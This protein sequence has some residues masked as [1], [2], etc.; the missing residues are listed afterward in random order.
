MDEVAR[1]Y[2]NI[3]ALGRE[4]RNS[5]VIL[6]IRGANNFI[7]AKITEE[8]V[9]AG[10]TVM[11]LGCGKGG[12]LRKME[13]R[14]IRRYHGYDIADQSI[15][16]AKR[17]ARGLSFEAVLEAKDVYRERIDVVPVDKV[18]SQ[19]SFHYAFSS[20]ESLRIALGNVRRNLREGGL[21]VVTVPNEQTVKRRRSKHGNKFG[22]KHYRIEFPEE[23]NE[24]GG[25]PIE[26]GTGE[27]REM[28]EED[29]ASDSVLR[30]GKYLFYLQ[31]ALSGCPE[32]LVPEEIFLKEAGRAGLAL[33]RSEE[34]LSLLNRYMK[35]DRALYNKMVRGRLNMEEVAVIELY[36]LMVFERQLGE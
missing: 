10:D 2:N 4:E 33:L 34:F 22:N 18:V 36:K 16:E 29:R 6:R 25:L 27:I 24:E 30:K 9:A 11:D 8:Y 21:F 17:R 15:E 3:K 31:E 19:F 13:R 12:D 5:S 32:Y 1:H 7:K 23:E 14:K 35:G 28:S 20:L 26:S